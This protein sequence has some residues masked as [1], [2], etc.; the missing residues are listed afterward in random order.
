MNASELPDRQLP[1]PLAEG[2][3]TTLS[4]LVADEMDSARRDGEMREPIL[5]IRDAEI[6]DYHAT[7]ILA[8]FRSTIQAPDSFGG[9]WFKYKLDVDLLKQG[10]NTLEVEAKRFE[11]TAGFTRSISGVEIQTRYKDFVLPEGLNVERMAPTLY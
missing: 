11:P 7:R 3:T 4:I 8:K 1:A 5:T 2:K 9:Y 10:D 6:S